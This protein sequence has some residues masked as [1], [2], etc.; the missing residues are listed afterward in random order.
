M[1]KY[2]IA[3]ITCVILTF[4]FIIYTVTTTTGTT[5]KTAVEICQNLVADMSTD[6]LT[7]RNVNFINEKYNVSSSV[8]SSVMCLSSDDVMNV[9]EIF[10]GVFN[11]EADS[12]TI[13][14][15]ES[16][17][18]DRFNL[19]NGYAPEQSALI[20]NYILEVSSG[21]LF[22]CI[23]DNAQAIYSEFLKNV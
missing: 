11:E 20:D 3:E 9:K 19:Y 12:E 2:I 4:S 13:C 10:V 21:A 15:F 16:Y 18:E 23:D 8:F 1:K 22:F 14:A 6:D 7:E 17:A 5:E